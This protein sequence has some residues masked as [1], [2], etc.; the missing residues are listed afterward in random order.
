[1][2]KILF[3]ALP[4]SQVA[5]IDPVRS[6]LLEPEEFIDTVGAIRSEFAELHYEEQETVASGD[7]VISVV[8][9]TGKH[10]FTV[11]VTA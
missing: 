3:L 7:K 6:K 10:T 9:V 2:N 8:K 1:M 5:Q 11:R 4:I